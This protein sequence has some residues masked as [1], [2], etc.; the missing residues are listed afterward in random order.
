MPL[1]TVGAGA[2]YL[3]AQ[4]WATMMAAD[5]T[6]AAAEG[7]ATIADGEVAVLQVVVDWLKAA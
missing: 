5:D 3:Q 2:S 1:G 6:A 7:A 4:S